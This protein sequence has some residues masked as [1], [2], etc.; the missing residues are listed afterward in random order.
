MIIVTGTIPIS[1]DHRQKAVQAMLSMQASTKPE[2]GCLVYD[3]YSALNDSN[4]MY[5]YEE[6]ESEAALA[7][8][9][10]APHMTVF[11]E[12]IRPMIG[13]EPRIF[14]HTVSGSRLIS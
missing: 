11:L 4:L 1:P 5:V 13:G 12:E 6:W 9:N 2:A 7:A 10:Q 14:V 3:F 8:H